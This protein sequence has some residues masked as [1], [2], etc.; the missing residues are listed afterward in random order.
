MALACET[1]NR[2]SAT[3][4]VTQTLKVLAADIAKQEL[5]ALTPGPTVAAE[6]DDAGLS[7]WGAQQMLYLRQLPQLGCVRVLNDP[8]QTMSVTP[9]HNLKGST[10]TRVSD[11]DFFAVF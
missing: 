10:N 7:V 3:A 2:S 8:R 1:T 5:C 11:A 6:V 9:L 4:A